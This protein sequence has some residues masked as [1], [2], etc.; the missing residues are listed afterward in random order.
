MHGLAN[1]GAVGPPHRVPQ[2]LV[3]EG[4]AVHEK[5]G[6]ARAGTRLVGALQEAAHPA[7]LPRPREP[8]HGGAGVS[9]PQP[10]DP[11]G[12]AGVGGQI[13]QRAPIGG[14]GERDLGMGQ[15]ERRE[16]GGHH[17]GF[18]GSAL[19]EAPARGCIE[20]EV[21]R[22]QGGAAGPRVI[23]DGGDGP[24]GRPNAGARAR[25]VAGFERQPRHR[26]D[27]GQCLA[28]KA[29]AR[30]PTQLPGARDL[31]GCVA[32]EAHDRI[33]APH[34]DSVVDHPD[35]LPPAPLHLDPDV[36][37]A[38]VQR[39]LDKLLHDRRRTLDYFT[40]G[41]LVRHRVRKHLDG[42]D[43]RGH[44]ASCACRPKKRKALRA[45]WRSTSSGLSPRTS[46]TP[47]RTRAT[48]AGSLRRPRCGTGAR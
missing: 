7:D 39:V 28:S 23:V 45:V 31:A 16:L 6:A 30:D 24:P 47:S 21:G 38:G 33:L 41:D 48:Y 29:E 17:P 10:A 42:P 26:R 18:R 43:A 11:A 27:R 22:L 36:R 40:G 8:E 3:P 1:G 44:P 12:G 34:A 4:S 2:A 13:H 9:A 46:A 35:A 37:G 14:E 25:L 15:G 32:L 19:Q 5:A 20:E